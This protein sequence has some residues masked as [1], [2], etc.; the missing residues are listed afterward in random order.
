MGIRGRRSTRRGWLT[1]LWIHRESS[2]SSLHRCIGSPTTGD[3]R[4]VPLTVVVTEPSSWRLPGLGWLNPR[5]TE[6]GSRTD[7]RVY[8]TAPALV[9]DLGTH[10]RSPA[11]F[12]LNLRSWLEF[13]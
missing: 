6:S 5:P 4:P 7:S 10:G 12:R 2:K 8:V 11:A 13:G 9:G 1:G 3:S